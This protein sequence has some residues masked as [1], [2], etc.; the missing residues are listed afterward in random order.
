MYINQQIN[1]TTVELQ[2]GIKGSKMDSNAN[3]SISSKKEK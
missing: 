3:R 2:K 1:I